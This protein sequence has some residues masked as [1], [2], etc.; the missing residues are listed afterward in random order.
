LCYPART[1]NPVRRSCYDDYLIDR[2]CIYVADAM[3]QSRSHCLLHRLSASF[4]CAQANEWQ[5]NAVRERYHVFNF[6][7]P[8]LAS[9][10]RY[11]PTEKRQD[12][13]RALPSVTHLIS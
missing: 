12:L 2:R 4:E 3:L 11:Q 7:M 5:I 10:A 13:T 1:S 6:H 8:C 9:F